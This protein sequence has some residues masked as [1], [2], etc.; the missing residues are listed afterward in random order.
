MTE[1]AAIW[2]RRVAEWK[3]SGLTSEAYSAGRDFTAGGLRHWSHR[4]G[5]TVARDTE[6][7]SV[8]LAR[9]VRRRTEAP[10]A[11]R[12]AVEGKAEGRL[13]VEVGEA[14]VVVPRGFDA[15]TLEAVLDVLGRRGGAK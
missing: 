2:A 9:V 10:S 6:T 13:V 4:L 3:S 5:K 7:P 15:M 11:A 8:R 14:R 1:K 12:V